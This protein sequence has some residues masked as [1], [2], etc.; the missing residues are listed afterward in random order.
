[1]MND[2]K[3]SVKKSVIT[4]VLWIAALLSALVFVGELRTYIHSQAYLSYVEK[5][6]VAAEVSWYQGKDYAEDSDKTVSTADKAAEITSTAEADD[7]TTSQ[8]KIYII[9]TNSRKI[10]SYNCPL[11]ENIKEKNREEISEDNL[12]HYLDNGYTYCGSCKGE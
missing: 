12:Q 8:A 6:E 2:E 3:L 10:H 4:A 5:E 9:N 7:E 11:A 1:M